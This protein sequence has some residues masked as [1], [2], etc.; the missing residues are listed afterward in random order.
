MEKSD[1]LAFFHRV[2]GVPEQRR[3][4]LS[5]WHTRKPKME[6]TRLSEEFYAFF[7]AVLYEPLR[8]HMHADHFCIFGTTLPVRYAWLKQQADLDFVAKMYEQRREL[9]ATR[10]EFENNQFD[11]SGLVK[12]GADSELMDHT[13]RRQL[14]RDFVWMCHMKGVADRHITLNL[15][16][17]VQTLL[18]TP[19]G[20]GDVFLG[21]LHQAL[22]GKCNL[23]EVVCWDNSP[24]DVH[25]LIPRPGG[26]GDQ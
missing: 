15:I 16:V 9:F 2:F 8:F 25:P 6:Y 10:K 4:L 1:F 18:V 14:A 26:A 24:Y 12:V 13:V 19:Q 7:Y 20:K 3:A 22:Q 23:K 17:A 21:A 5:Q 11:Y